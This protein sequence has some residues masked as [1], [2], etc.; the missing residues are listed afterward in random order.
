M[1]TSLSD[2]E[3][4]STNQNN[5]LCRTI[6]TRDDEIVENSAFFSLQ[7]VLRTENERVSVQPSSLNITI[8]DDDRKLGVMGRKWEHEIDDEGTIVPDS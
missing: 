4:N 6:R 8:V 2:L 3:F 7:L 5:Q 1:E